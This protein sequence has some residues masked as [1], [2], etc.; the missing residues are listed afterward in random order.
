MPYALLLV[1]IAILIFLG[2]W[3]DTLLLLCFWLA[4]TFRPRLVPVRWLSLV[5]VHL[6]FLFTAIWYSVVLFHW[7]FAS[8]RPRTY[9]EFRKPDWG[10]PQTLAS[11]LAMLSLLAFI[12]NLVVGIVRMA[13][14]KSH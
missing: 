9:Y 1:S 14:S 4:Y 12:S 11:F 2:D 8:P 13:R 5:N 7:R 3:F 6:A 10:N